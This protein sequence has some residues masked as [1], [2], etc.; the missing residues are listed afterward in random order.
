MRVETLSDTPSL[1]N[2]YYFH[3]QLKFIIDVFIYLLLF[4]ISKITTPIPMSDFYSDWTLVQ[5]EGGWREHP[6][7]PMGDRITFIDLTH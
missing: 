3:N 5:Q 2:Y 1:V 4:L 6:P 7:L